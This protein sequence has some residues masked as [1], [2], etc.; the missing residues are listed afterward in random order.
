MYRIFKILRKLTIFSLYRNKRSFIFFSNIIRNDFK[1]KW[2]RILLLSPKFNY[3]LSFI[4]SILFI[5]KFFIKYETKIIDEVSDRRYDHQT[6]S[7]GAILL[8]I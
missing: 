2:D 6:Y 1:F 4:K 7:M 5:A 8:T 3:I